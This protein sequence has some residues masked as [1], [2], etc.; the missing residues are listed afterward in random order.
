MVVTAE[1]L[2]VGDI[3]EGATILTF[4]DVVGE[5]TGR[6]ADMATVAMGG[7]LALVS[8]TLQHC[9]APGLMLRGA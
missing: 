5:E 2:P 7:A 1:T 6:G 9:L 8:G 3:V 4:L